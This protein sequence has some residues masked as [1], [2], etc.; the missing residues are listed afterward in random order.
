MSAFKTFKDFLKEDATFGKLKSLEHAEDLPI[1]SGAEGFHKSVEALHQAHEHVKTG[2]SEAKV[3]TKYDGSPSLVFGHHPES[4][5]FFVATKSLFNKTPKI[6]YTPADI[7]ANHGHAPGLVEHMKAALTHLKKVAPKKGVYQGD[8]MYTN[9]SVQSDETHHHFTP[10]TITYS[11]KKDSPEGKKI[12][13]AKLG[14]VVHTKYHGSTLDN[15]N[16]SFNPDV[17][18]FKS[19]KDVHLISAEE[20][21]AHHTPENEAAYTK[22]IEAAKELHKN[23]HPDMHHAVNLVKDHMLIHVNNTIRNGTKPS[24]EGLKKHLPEW[25]GKKIDAYK[26]EKSKAPLR[27]ELAGHMAHIEANKKHIETAFQIHHHLQQAK[28]ALV[29]SLSQHPT[30]EHSINGHKT[31]PEG[32]VIS[33]RGYP[34]KLVNREDFSRQNLLK[35]GSQFAKKPTE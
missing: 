23:A 6:N 21:K 29:S 20:N 16:A 15:M 31:G 9:K 10:N 24:F 4:G 22:H 14:M 3:T 5:K 33:H 13:Q 25:Y 27:T 12:S 8:L 18:N 2:H 17:H 26:T 35:Q 11:T 32:F 7:E 1:T 19:H 34:I 28:N 30:F